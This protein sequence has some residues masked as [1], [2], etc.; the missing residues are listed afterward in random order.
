MKSIGKYL[1]KLFLFSLICCHWTLYVSAQVKVIASANKQILT[2]N[3]L[4]TLH[5]SVENADDVQQFI[6]PSFTGCKI[7]QG[8]THINSSSVINGVKSNA[9]SFVYVVQPAAPGK[10]CFSGASAKVNGK[11]LVFNTLNI[12]VKKIPGKS[13]Y[14]FI[15]E[16]GDDGRHELYSDYILRRN[17][18]IQDKIRKNLFI[19]VDVDK[20]LCYEGEAVVATYKLYTRLRSESK[21]VRRPSFNGFSVYDM[22]DPTVAPSTIEKLNGKDFNVY[23]IR[24]VQLFPLQSGSLELDAAEVENSITFLKADDAIKNNGNNLSA[25]L[26]AF[27]MDDIKNSGIATEQVSI[28]SNPIAITVKPLPEGKP[29]TFNGAV[30]SFSIQSTVSKNQIPLN[31]AAV[32]KVIIKGE[33]NF[34]VMNTPVIHWAKS[35]DAYEP[36]IKEDFLKNVVP[37]RGYKAYEFT[38]TP[39][40]T[41]EVVLDPVEFSFFDPVANQYKT[42]NTDAIKIIATAP[43]QQGSAFL[44]TMPNNNQETVSPLSRPWILSIAGGLLFLF[45]YV[46]Y[47][48]IRASG[49]DNT[50]APGKKTDIP[51]KDEMPAN[52]KQSSS[53]SQSPLFNSKLMLVQQN[54]RGFYS[55]LNRALRNYV[56][57]KYNLSYNLN[58]KELEQHMKLKGVDNDVVSQFSLVVQQCEI[59]L[60]NP[61]LNEAD[62]QSVYEL[63]EDFIFNTS[64]I[65]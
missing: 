11:R 28:R 21:V 54:S 58:I 16:E 7:V 35:I 10:Y 50:P 55:E 20:T 39:K 5:F 48:Y 52:N 53:I 34:G 41:G 18:N 6:P 57:E 13:R 33:G 63:A 61:Y 36:N 38:F 64:K 9:L 31:D 8:P 24:K 62:M 15:E 17:E 59:A 25:L 60:Y 22:L 42:I 19:K 3:D 2:P 65:S 45:A 49:S 43:L 14:D 23:L 47:R 40:Q 26:R 4:L 30:G 29:G 27:E 56:S 46:L 44:N 37:M 51:V 12:L 32:F 1:R